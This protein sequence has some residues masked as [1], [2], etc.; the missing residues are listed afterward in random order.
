VKFFINL[1]KSDKLIIRKTFKPNHAKLYI[2]KLEPSQ[3]RNELF[4]TGSS[5]LTKAGLT[6][7]QEFNV[8]ISDYG[9]KDAEQ[10]FDNLW[11]TAVK[12]TEDNV[13]KQKLIETLENET[14]IKQLIP[15]EAYALV[16]KSYLET[17]TPKDVGDEVIKSHIR[18]K[19][20]YTIPLPDRCSK[21][22]LGYNRK[23]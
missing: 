18:E 5:N 20:F 23:K 10:Y 19:W 13:I 1:I 9:T 8:E 14:L 15:F 16:L 3:V 6:Q 21:T 4:I 12:I 17:Y 11:E 22:S 2:F 7:D